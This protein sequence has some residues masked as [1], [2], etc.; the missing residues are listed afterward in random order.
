M[1]ETSVKEQYKTG[2]VRDYDLAA[3]LRVPD[4]L[5]CGRPGDIWSI[6]VRLPRCVRLQWE[7]PRAARRA[8]S[9]CCR[10]CTAREH[11]PTSRRCAASWRDTARASQR[12]PKA[13]A[14]LSAARLQRKLVSSRRLGQRAGVERPRQSRLKVPAILSAR[15]QRKIVSSRNLDQRRG[16]VLRT[17]RR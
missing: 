6:E 16:K 17:C 8:Q 1:N 5:H 9:R 7:Q 15:R 11:P 4:V 10:T 2:H 14:V 12:S 13:P 3:A